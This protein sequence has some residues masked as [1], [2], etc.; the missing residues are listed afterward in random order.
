M[1]YVG[2]WENGEMIGQGTFTYPYG[3]KYVGEYKDG[4][5]LQRTKYQKG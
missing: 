2:G 5:Q 3:E 4:K 1:K